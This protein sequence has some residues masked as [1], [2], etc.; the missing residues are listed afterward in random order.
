M[1][2]MDGCQATEKIIA[3]LKDVEVTVPKIVGISGHIEEKYI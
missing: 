2:Q 1:P 3:Y